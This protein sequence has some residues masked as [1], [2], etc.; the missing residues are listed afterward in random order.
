MSLSPD[1]MR[2]QA[3]AQI[4]MQRRINE[5]ERPGVLKKGMKAAKSMEEMQIALGFALEVLKGDGAIADRDGFVAKL[6]E[7]RARA[8]ALVK[9]FAMAESRVRSVNGRAGQ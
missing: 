9:V 7:S 1:Q 8:E 3:M 5:S 2:A 6:R 4:E